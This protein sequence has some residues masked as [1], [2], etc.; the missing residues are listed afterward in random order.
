MALPLTA[1]VLAAALAP[2]PARLVRRG[3]AEAHVGQSFIAVWRP[4]ET[5][6]RISSLPSSVRLTSA[7]P[8]SNSLERPPFDSIGVDLFLDRAPADEFMDEDVLR[9]R[10]Q[11]QNEER[12]P[13]VLL[14]ILTSNLRFRTSVSPCSV[15]PGRPK[16]PARSAASGSITARNWVKTSIS[17]GAR[18]SP[19][20]SRAG[21]HICRYPLPSTRDRP[22][23]AR[24][25]VADLLQPH[26][27]G[28]HRSL[29]G[30]PIGIVERG[31]EIVDGLPAMELRRS[32]P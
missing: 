4:R 24:G 26:Q 22:A 8:S 31:A 30:N 6:R 11:R 16:R 2:E 10:L 29:A 32:D 23:I 1:C 21:A 7:D 15:R 17:P 9:R 25:M 28:Q 27:R 19:R 18:R 13:L 14:E 12:D 5:R 3:I 20:R